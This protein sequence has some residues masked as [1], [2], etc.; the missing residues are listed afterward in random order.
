MRFGVLMASSDMEVPQVAAARRTPDGALQKAKRIGIRQARLVDVRFSSIG[1]T[2]Q[3]NGNRID[4]K[5]SREPNCPV[6]HLD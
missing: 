6:L 1:V 2:G 4:V 5:F 3:L